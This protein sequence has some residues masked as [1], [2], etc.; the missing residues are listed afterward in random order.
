MIILITGHYP[1]TDKYGYKTGET[2]FLT[3]HGVD[4]DSGQNIVVPQVHPKHLG[5]VFN[6]QMQ[7]WVLE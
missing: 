5:G 7:E 2:E 1:K 3:S 4:I 6:Q